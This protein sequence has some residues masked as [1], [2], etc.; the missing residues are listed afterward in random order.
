MRFAI[1]AAAAL[2]AGCAS[3]PHYDAAAAGDS[4]KVAK[5][6]EL[7]AD[8]NLPGAAG[9]LLVSRAACD[10]N[11]AVLEELIR[12]GARLND[13]SG[14]RIR[15]RPLMAAIMCDMPQHPTTVKLLLDSGA[16]VE[17]D[18]VRPGNLPAINGMLQAAYQRQAAGPPTSPPPTKAAE[19][20]EPQEPAASSAAPAAWWSK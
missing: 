18:M 12:H 11:D 5:L 1:L 8:P 3:T 13:P 17:N 2:A 14:I 9:W 7:G 15:N 16:K 4:V 6:L 19:N 10:G 20:P